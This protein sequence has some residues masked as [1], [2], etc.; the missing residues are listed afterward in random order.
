M[1]IIDQ[2]LPTHRCA[3]FSKYTRMTI[4]RL[5]ENWAAAALSRPA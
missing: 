5:S 1:R 3:G 4:N 2:A